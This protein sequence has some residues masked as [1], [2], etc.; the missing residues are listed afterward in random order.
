MKVIK[1]E[2]L[3]KCTSDNRW[4]TNMPE[5]TLTLSLDCDVTR[6]QLL[7]CEPQ[8]T[9]TW[10]MILPFRNRSCLKTRKQECVFSFASH[11]MH[12]KIKFRLWRICGYQKSKWKLKGKWKKQQHFPSADEYVFER[13][14]L[15][16]TVWRRNILA[17]IVLSKQ[18]SRCHP[19]FCKIFMTPPHTLLGEQ[20]DDSSTQHNH[21][22]CAKHSLHQSRWH[23]LFPLHSE[24]ASPSIQ[25]PRWKGERRWSSQGLFRQAFFFSQCQEL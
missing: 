22:G 23:D 1:T 13:S 21:L 10:K 5:S 20:I 2:G 14:E 8:N 18:E 3:W 7:L 12:N 16:P 19:T 6:T 11:Q 9:S 15:G 25:R 4:L 24:A 17:G